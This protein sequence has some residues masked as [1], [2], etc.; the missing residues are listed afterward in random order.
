[1]AEEKKEKN[2]VQS[3]ADIRID[4]DHIDVAD[5]MGQIKRKVAAEP[6][7]E[8]PGAF[9]GGE[10]EPPGPGTEP[11]GSG[12]GRSRLKRILIKVMR[13]F[14]PLIKLLV[15]PVHE[16][17]Q[18]TIQT[19]DRTNRR[20]DAVAAR[21]GDFALD[22]TM[23]QIN[24]EVNER[25]NKAFE[26]IGRSKEYI[27]L[28]HGLEHNLVVEITKLKIESENLKLKLRIAEKDFEFLGRREKALEEEVFK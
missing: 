24:A 21:L 3:D 22:S 2:G 18:E 6:E 14:S 27:K 7:P 8:D 26:D 12:G 16:Q 19:L 5:I 25:V 10:V 13:P 20:L 28:M 11:P 4:Y 15:L 17:L 1:M 9:H 23:H